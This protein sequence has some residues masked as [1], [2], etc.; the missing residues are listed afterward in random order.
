MWQQDKEDLALLATRRVAAEALAN[1]KKYQQQPDVR[2]LRSKLLLC[3]VLS[4][5]PEDSQ[6]PFTVL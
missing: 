6:Q 3:Q 4:V 5:T 1:S 2:A